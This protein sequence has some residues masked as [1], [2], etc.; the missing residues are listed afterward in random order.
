LQSSSIEDP[1]V[2]AQFEDSQNRIRS[3]ALI[4]ERLYRSNDLARIE[5]GSY[6]R[7]LA[8]S[9]VQ[10]YRGQAQRIQLKVEADTILMDIDTA[11]PCGL[12]VNELV[13]NALKHAFPDGRKG[14]IGIEMCC[15]SDMKYRLTMW[16]DGVGIPDGMDWRNTTSLGLQLVINLSRQLGGTVEMKSTSGTLFEIEF[17]AAALRKV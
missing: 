8:A 10:T 15:I 4:H 14:E 16:D 1:L 11:I 7:D 5:F 6:L 3:M 12:L 9:L 2:R 13:S 17:P